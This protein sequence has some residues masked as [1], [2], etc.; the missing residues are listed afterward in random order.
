MMTPD[1][2]HS[3]TQSTL[4]WLDLAGISVFAVSGALAAAR[5]GQTMVTFAF[6]ASVT[7]IGGGTMRDLL[8]GAP[9][10]WMHD[11][12]WISACLIVAV[13]VWFTPQRLW[14]LRAVEWF[15]AVGLAAYAVYGSGKALAYGIPPLPA[16]IMGVVTACLGGILRDMLA[17]TP[18]IVM[19]PELYVTAA[20][21]A[22]GLYV[23]LTSAGIQPWVAAV[24]AAGA[25]FALRALALWRGL[26]LPGYHR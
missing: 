14:P 22:S 5:A 17:G 16:A 19:R 25:G 3:L 2:I 4:P 13:A 1:T 18:S 8:I 12:V 10:F 11:P 15:D 26:A 9:V 6:F 24:L 23:A 7:A 20:A 21:A